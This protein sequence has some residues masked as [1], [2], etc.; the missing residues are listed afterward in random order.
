[1]IATGGGTVMAA[2]T[3]LTATQGP[4]R[5]YYV[6]TTGSDAG[7]GTF[8]QPFQTIQK[9][10]TVMIPGD[11]TF[12]RAGVY[13]EAVIPKNSGTPNAAITFMPF[14][15]ESVTVSGADVVPASSWTLSSGNIYKAP[16]SWDMAQA[17]IK[18]SSIAK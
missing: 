17:P 15:G 9:A 13:R 10:A 5:S 4:A 6:S 1:M 18:S 11:T 7:P 12:I 3:D 2:G 14:N 8:D 16:I